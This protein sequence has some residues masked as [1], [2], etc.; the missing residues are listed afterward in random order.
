[1]FDFLKKYP[2]HILFTAMYLAGLI[3]LNFETT[4]PF[5]LF[6]TPIHLVA[7]CVV[8]LY[9]QED[10][11]KSFQIFALST[12][13]IGFFIEMLGVNTGLVF[14]QYRYETTLGFKIFGTPPVIGALWLQL[15][16]CFGVLVDKIKY[17][18]LIKS[19]LGSALMTA[20]DV[21]TE[22]VA[23]R[24][25]MW[26]WANGTPPLQ[27]Y[28]AWFVVSFFVFLLFFKLNFKRNNKIAIWILFLTFVF[29]IGNAIVGV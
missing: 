5:F 6:F 19:I 4:K 25:K 3:G 22:P 27:N 10:W 17:N 7:A 15:S 14:G 12:F 23:I 13:L 8:V 2:F 26:S 16:Y 21:V 24:F 9:F 29:F 1:M 28:V 18:T 20:L 11:S